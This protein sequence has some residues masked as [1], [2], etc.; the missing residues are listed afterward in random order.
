L[1][2]NVEEVLASRW[3]ID[4]GQTVD[5]PFPGAGEFGLNVRHAPGRAYGPQKFATADLDE[6]PQCDVVLAHSRNTHSGPLEPQMLP[7]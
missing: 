2:F 1:E 3:R 5:T 7:L 6:V 4:N